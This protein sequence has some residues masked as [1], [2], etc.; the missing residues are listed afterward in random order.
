M[1]G[2]AGDTTGDLAGFIHDAETG[3]D[4]EFEIETVSVTDTD[5]VAVNDLRCLLCYTGIVIYWITD[6]NVCY[7]MVVPF[8]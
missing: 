6:V 8:I 1:T 7:Q 4:T 5:T 3:D 2:W